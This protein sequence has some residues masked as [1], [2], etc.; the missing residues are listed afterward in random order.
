MGKKQPDF[1][2]NGI[3]HVYN[4]AN[5]WEDI[6]KD[7]ENY[8]YFLQKMGDY[9]PKVVDVLAYCLLS[10]HFHFLVQVKGQ[11]ELVHFHKQKYELSDSVFEEKGGEKALNIHK[12]VQQP[13]TNFLA[14][15]VSAFNKYHNR[16]GSL[17]RQNTCRKA[18]G[19]KAYFLNAIHYINR[20]AV[21][22]NIVGNIE[23]WPHSSFHSYLSTGQTKLA[24]EKVLKWFGGKERFIDFSR[25]PVDPK[26]RFHID[27]EEE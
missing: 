18:V 7:Q 6:F 27:F 21:H 23:D 3:Y 25:N 8:R 13:F 11:D 17:L 9:V 2:P 12:L 16:K 26:Y 15:Y 20:N 1:V 22:H 5:G 19:N 10:N 4:H 14:G 24:R